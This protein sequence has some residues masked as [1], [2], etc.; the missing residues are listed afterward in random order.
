[1]NRIEFMTELAAL[2]QDVPEEE[3]RDAMQFYNDYFDDAGEDKESEVISELESPKKVAE[4][5]KADLL[6]QQAEREYTETGC[7]D[8]STDGRSMPVKKA[9]ASGGCDYESSDNGQSSFRGACGT[10]SGNYGYQEYRYD[11]ETQDKEEQK[12]WSSNILKVILIIAIILVGAPIIIPCALAIV[13]VA[14]ACIVSLFVFFFAIVI[15]FAAI[16]IV[17]VVLVC[18]GL[19]ALIPEIAVGLALIGTGLIL[20]VIGAI[21]TVAG[22]KLCIVIIPG[23]CR[24]VVW[25][26]SRPFHRKAVA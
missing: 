9:M 16:A 10:D 5:I 18:A 17:G 22:V 24:G 15:G 4:K 7:R 1:M 25:I 2:L 8:G 12:P 23:I 6:G 26:F 19:M 11:G 21:G 20:G 3:R 13:L 14:V